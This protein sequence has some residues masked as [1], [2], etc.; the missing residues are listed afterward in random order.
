MKTIL[1]SICLVLFAACEQGPAEK[2]VCKVGVTIN[3]KPYKVTDGTKISYREANG[4]FAALKVEI[5]ES[6]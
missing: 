4:R 5:P 6:H 2:A 3:D 1:F